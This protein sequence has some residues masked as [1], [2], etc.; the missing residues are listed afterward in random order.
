[1]VS[2]GTGR[3]VVVVPHRHGG[4][5]ARI[6]EPNVRERRCIGTLKRERGA[7]TTNEYVYAPEIS[8]ERRRL[9]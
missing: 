5:N 6:D 8:K 2:D 9:T 7:E 4:T 3:R 1:M